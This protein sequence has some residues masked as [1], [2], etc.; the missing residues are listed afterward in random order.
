[1]DDRFGFNY[2]S[3]YQFFPDET[4][5]W[6]VITAEPTKWKAGVAISFKVKEKNS[7]GSWKESFSKWYYDRDY[8]QYREML[9]ILV[10]GEVRGRHAEDLIYS[11]FMDVC[12]Y[13]N[14]SSWV[15]DIFPDFYKRVVEQRESLIKEK[16]YAVMV[17]SHFLTTMAKSLDEAVALTRDRY[18][19]LEKE[20][21][22]A[23][24][25]SEITRYPVGGKK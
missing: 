24:P 11:F 7:D 15:K 14:E 12:F 23:V 13:D 8:P 17:T 2:A 1:M 21:L 16:E 5:K 9:G 6:K 4:D 18:P 10:D 3:Y 25:F 19:E 22:I 20:F